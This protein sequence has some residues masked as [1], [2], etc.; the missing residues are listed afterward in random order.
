MIN[1]FY[2]AISFNQD[3]SSWNVSKITDMNWMFYG[4]TSF[5]QDISNWNTQENVNTISMFEGASSLNKEIIIN[6]YNNKR[7]GKEE[8]KKLCLI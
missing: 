5:N 1:M 6:F 3:I 8:L 4:V 7:E 2:N